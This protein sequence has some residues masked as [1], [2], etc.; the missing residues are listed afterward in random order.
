MPEA[1]KKPAFARHKSEAFHAADFT[2]KSDEYESTKKS[3]SWKYCSE[4]KT[5]DLTDRMQ[6]LYQDYLD[7]CDKIREIQ[8]RKL[9]CITVNRAGTKVE[10]Y[11]WDEPRFAS[12][13]KDEKESEKHKHQ[14]LAQFAKLAEPVAEL[15]QKAQCDVPTLD[16]LRSYRGKLA[17]HIAVMEQRRKSRLVDLLTSSRKLCCLKLTQSVH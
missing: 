4:T 10:L 12:L 1:K 9:S 13:E 6:V 3:S 17:N 7:E 16:G 8:S 11:V 5:P 14:I 15:S 2:P